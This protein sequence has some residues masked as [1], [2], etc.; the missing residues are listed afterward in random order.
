MQIAY[1]TLY[2]IE[3]ELMSTPTILT[4]TEK[5][6]NAQV[7]ALDSR[8][9]DHVSSDKKFLRILQLSDLLS[10]SL[11]IADVIK[12]FSDE[13]QD[14]IAHKAYR[15]VSDKIGAPISMGKVNRYS[16]NYRLTLHDQPLGELTIYRTKQFSSNE[17]CDFEDL[18]CSLIYPIKNALMYQTALKSAYVDPLT[19]LGNRTAM[20]KFLP[21]EIGLA[22]RHEHSMALLLMDLDGFKDINDGCGH[23]VGDLVLEEVGAVLQDAL[24]NTDLLYRYGG[25]E[26]INALPQTDM[27]G[28]LDVAERVRK[29]IAQ[30]KIPQTGEDANISISI[31][32]TMVQPGDDFAKSFKRADKALYK[33]KKSGKNRIIVA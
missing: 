32:V 12:V 4:V 8:K 18:L 28:A 7:I 10:R 13:I 30:L 6:R 21:R 26:F 25:D 15:F 31:G 2:L 23:D 1:I 24:R 27:Q 11:E 20:E 19:H 9:N 33:A 22:K 29:G 16:M 17:V 3:D 14:V 5:T